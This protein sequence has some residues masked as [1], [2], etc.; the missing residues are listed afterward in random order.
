MMS[1]IRF[2]RVCLIDDTFFD[3]A[4]KEAMQIQKEWI[5]AVEEG[6]DSVISSFDVHDGQIFIKASAIVFMGENDPELRAKNREF[7]KALNKEEEEIGK[8]NWL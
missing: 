6:K 8:P 7:I 2:W 5:K 4:Y 3:V 1:D